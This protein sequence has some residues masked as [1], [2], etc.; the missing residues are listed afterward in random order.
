MPA[1]EDNQEVT[2]TYTNPGTYTVTLTVRDARGAETQ[3]EKEITVAAPVNEPPRITS[4]TLDPEDP[5]TGQE[6]TFNATAAD[7]E[8]DAIVAWQWDFDGDGNVDSTQ[9]PPV[10]H[11]YDQEGVYTVRVRAKDEGSDTWGPWYER[12]VYVRRQGGPEIG[13]YVERNPVSTQATIAYFPPA[14][15]TNVKLS[16]FDLMGRLVFEADL[17]P[18]TNTYNWNLQTSGGA[19]VPS[20][21]YFFVITAEKDGRTIRSA[22][23]RILVVR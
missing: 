18:A 9:A 7:P 17:N 22:V 4:L 14:V 15:T 6:V 5:V 8:D 12:S 16:I 21:L 10:T 23:G 2:H 20:G 19:D 3:V 13:G 11:T 1:S